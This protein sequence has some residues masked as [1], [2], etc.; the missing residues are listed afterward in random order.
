MS[1]VTVDNTFHFS[2][3]HDYREPP[4]KGTPI[5]ITDRHQLFKDQ[6]RVA[7]PISSQ[8]TVRLKQ[9]LREGQCR[10]H[11]L[12]IRQTPLRASSALLSLP[13]SRSLH[14]AGGPPLDGGSHQA[15][16]QD[17]PFRLDLHFQGPF[18]TGFPFCVTPGAPFT[19]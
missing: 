3:Q 10:Q 13:R 15:A 16:P 6:T 7:S 9:T 8:S 5:P 2:S 11:H 4:S 12:V 17:L 19:M 14:R 1:T 18:H